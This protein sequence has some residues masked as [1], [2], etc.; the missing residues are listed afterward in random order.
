MLHAHLN[1]GKMDS[2]IVTYLV[3]TAFVTILGISYI[4]FK[5]REEDGIS[6]QPNTDIKQNMSEMRDYFGLDLKQGKKSAID[7]FDL[8]PM[9]ILS[10]MSGQSGNRKPSR[11]KKG[12]KR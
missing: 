9:Q 5:K 12:R 11:A 1:G 3:V 4:R 2:S 10:E 7:A 8:V 6:Q